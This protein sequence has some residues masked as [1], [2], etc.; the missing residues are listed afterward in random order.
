VLLGQLREIYIDAELEPVDTT[1]WY[2]RLLRRDF[3]VGLN[4]SETGV[5]DPDQQFYENYVC[6]SER[7]YTGYCNPE[8]D[9]LVDRQSRETNFDKRKTL[10]WEIERRLV[11]D[12]ARPVIFYPRGGTCRKPEVKGLTI[13]VNSIYNGWRM[14][15]VW[16]DR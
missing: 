9:R 14:E 6:G 3:T 11:E 1:Q 7:N 12:G 5:D 10:V 2:P 15:D 4:V 16:L 13:M 8:V